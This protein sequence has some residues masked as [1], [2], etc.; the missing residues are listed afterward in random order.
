MKVIKEGLL[1]ADFNLRLELQ[2]ALVG[3]FSNNLFLRAY[4]ELKQIK[5][6]KQKLL[7]FIGRYKLEPLKRP[8]E[9]TC[10]HIVAY[11]QERLIVKYSFDFDIKAEQDI[12]VGGTKGNATNGDISWNGIA[13]DLKI[14]DSNLLNY[15]RN[16]G[17]VI[18]SISKEILPLNSD[19]YYLLID[20][21]LTRALFVK[22]EAVKKA[23]N[24]GSLKYYKGEYLK[25]LDL[26]REFESL[27]FSL[28]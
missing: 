22:S 28:K 24:S 19:V 25:G 2:Q 13:I 3:T 4:N 12:N 6:D 18:A 20:A 14:S 17:R 11:I 27:I 15:A 21:D 26:E 1:D 23:L 7:E 10:K 8:D 9:H 16:N 5:T